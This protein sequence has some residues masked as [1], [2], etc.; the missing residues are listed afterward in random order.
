MFSCV[1]IAPT[2]IQ[3]SVTEPPCRC[4]VDLLQASAAFETKVPVVLIMVLLS[5][6]S[7]LHV[8][9]TAS[10]EVAGTSIEL[11]VKERW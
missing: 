3:H 6:P 4:T 7:K 8:S 10:A 5:E 2:T 9:L 11:F 1:S